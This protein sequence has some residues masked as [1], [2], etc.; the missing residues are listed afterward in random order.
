MPTRFPHPSNVYRVFLSKDWMAHL[1]LQPGLKCPATTK[2]NRAAA[3]TD[4]YAAA[5]NALKSLDLIRK[6]QVGR[7]RALECCLMI[8]SLQKA[9]P[10][11]PPPPLPS[12]SS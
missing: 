7:E 3:E 6:V 4:P 12:L 9:L 8:S 11:L 5:V 1:C 2:V 10:L